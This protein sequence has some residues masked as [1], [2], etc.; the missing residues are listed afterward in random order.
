MAQAPAPAT[1]QIDLATIEVMNKEEIKEE[2]QKKSKCS[3]YVFYALQTI[4]MLSMFANA[5]NIS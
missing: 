4:N 3:T 1:T 2:I 5:I